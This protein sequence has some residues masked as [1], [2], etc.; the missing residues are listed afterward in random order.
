MSGRKKE[1][2]IAVPF[3]KVLGDWKQ[4][5]NWGKGGDDNS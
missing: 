1:E 5:S 2:L 3:T 4:F